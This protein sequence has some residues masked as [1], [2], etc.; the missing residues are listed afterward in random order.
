M[1][2]FR[3]FNLGVV[4]MHES[5]GPLVKN[6]RAWRA[7]GFTVAAIAIALGIAAP[8]F[9]AKAAPAAA[10]STLPPAINM[11]E[12]FV[13]RSIDRGYVIL[14]DTKI[15]EAQRQ[16]QFHDFLLGLMDARRIGM[17]TLGQYA[18]SASK[19]EIEAFVPAFADFTAAVY[20]TRLIKYKEQLLKVIGSTARADDDVVVNCN[21][22]DPAQPN[23]PPYKVAFRVRRS[24]EGKFIVTDMN[25][26]GIWQTLSQRADF[27]GFLQQ[28]GGRLGD[29]VNDLNRQTK[30]LYA[31]S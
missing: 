2:L 15:T 22:T 21:V 9:T 4:A 1:I 16:A 13:Q 30:L 18:N 10:A 25:I 24:A 31:S 27:T 29:L 26:E 19:T 5:H 14:K 23:A 7:G 20:E 6:R 8:A 28:H 17:F 11:A 3:T 12:A